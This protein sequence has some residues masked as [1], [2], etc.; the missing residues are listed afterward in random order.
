MIRPPSASR[1]PF[2]IEP[3][4]ARIAPAR[5]IQVGG[6]DFPNKADFNYADT[7]D[8]RNGL[9]L[10]QNTESGAADGDP[11]S[12]AVG[13]GAAGVA[14]TFYLRLGPGDK[15]KLFQ[16]ANSFI[17]YLSVS[18]GNLVGF[19]VDKN[20][21]GEVQAT[22]LVS[23]SLGRN[24]GFEL[25]SG[26][27]GDIVTNLNEQGTARLADDT[28]EMNDLVS[29][30][31]NIKSLAVRGGA[32]AG[33]ILAGGSVTNV[34]INDGMN[35]LLAGSAAFGVT[36][37][38]LPGVVG[39]TGTLTGKASN[40]AVVPASGVAGASIAGVSIS[41]VSFNTSIGD[42]IEAGGGGAGA[43]GGSLS[44]IFIADD[45]DGFTLRAGDGGDGDTIRK[46]GGA[47]GT[48]ST[49]YIAGRTDDLTPND[50][51][52]VRAGD[53]GSSTTGGNGGAAGFVSTV[54]VG[55]QFI[56]GKPLQSLGVLNDNLVIQSGE[57]GAGT[58][59][60]AGGAVVAINAV[61]NT[62]NSVG[63]EL[64]VIAGKGGDSNLASGGRPGFGGSLAKLTLRN[65]ADTTGV[66]FPVGVGA[67][68]LVQA[69]DGGTAAGLGLSAGGGSIN[70][71][72]LIGSDLKV[73]A[74]NGSNGRT[75]GGGGS[76]T[77]ISVTESDNVIAHNLSLRAGNGGNGSSGSGGNGG[78]INVVAVTNGDFSVIDINQSG[79]G[80][81]GTGNGGRGGFGGSV[82][83]L[84]VI[85]T[86]TN[87]VFEGDLRLRAGKGGDGTTGGG[88]G[89]SVVSASLEAVDMNILVASGSGGSLL[90]GGRGNAGGAGFARVSAA[91]DGRVGGLDT[92]V[93]VSAGTG[94][95]V[96]TGATG[97]GGNGGILSI[98]TAIA[99]G[100]VAL[101]AGNGGSGIS[102]AAGSGGSVVSAVAFSDLGNAAIQAGN[103]GVNGIRPGNGGDILGTA[104]SQSP[105]AYG[106]VDVSLIAGNGSHGGRGGAIRLVGFG[107]AAT[108]AV[109]APAGNITVQGGNGSNEGNFVGAGGSI[110]SIDGSVSTGFGKFTII[111]AGAG[112]GGATRA[113][114][115]GFVSTV[116]LSGGGG[117]GSEIRIDG[118]NAG[119]GGAGVAF[120][121][122]GGVVTGVQISNI[123]T[124]T[125]VRHIA[126]GD[127][128]DAVQ[129]GGTGGSINDVTAPSIDIGIRSGQAFGYNT[130]GGIFAG[131]GGAGLVKGVPGNVTNIRAGMIAAI[132]AGKTATPEEVGIVDFIYVGPNTNLLK[133]SD[134]D[135]NFADG[136]SAA[137]HSFQGGAYGTASLV[138][139]VVNPTAIDANQFRLANDVDGDGR[140]DLGDTPTDGLIVAKVFR[141]QNTNFTPEARFTAGEFYDYDNLI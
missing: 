71:A 114:G 118:G 2:S 11:I 62:P 111:A 52:V 105:G 33:N 72:T 74:G 43:R 86:V 124:G 66:P 10:F 130:M 76:I 32:V 94:G 12:L 113:A 30:L 58:V 45:T 17:D 140:F 97:S 126:G 121:A 75:G 106:A 14:D 141:Q 56:G 5:I 7:V 83:R 80:D 108:S 25:L 99:Q 98:V 127:G 116:S 24:V 82:G 122:A 103:A 54:F 73:F 64:A 81:G 46:S 15:L 40:S 68:I 110:S 36:F 104:T 37:D 41:N 53:G 35:S 125:V 109:S 34:V 4:E 50:V 92:T 19:F 137:W 120:G 84:S 63:D 23:L 20:L 31:Q 132:V 128:G 79:G 117:F 51:I 55:F 119:D 65:T 134:G 67:S 135:L 91:T 77:S 85:D 88:A 57:G 29:P 136:G 112:G 131:A 47:G 102:G 28:L 129:K 61:I 60:G 90:A 3:L 42:R 138:G 18:S 87:A 13:G 133:A 48:I 59:G 16:S 89:G 1:L 9:P 26:I 44:S 27:E 139:A 123:A 39:G 6:P 93:T 70:T 78:A 100:N 95:D 96:L 21:D 107:S 22:E 38:L 8:P 49:V 115:G 101:S 69:G